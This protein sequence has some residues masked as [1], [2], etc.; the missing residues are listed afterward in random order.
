MPTSKYSQWKQGQFK[1][2][3]LSKYKGS[4]P[5]IYRS[6][7]EYKVMRFFDINEN[8]ISWGSESVVIRY[9]HPIKNKL[10]SYYTDFNVEIKDASNIVRKYLIE[11]KPY[12]QTLPP[13]AHGNKKQKTILLEN[14]MYLINSAKWSAAKEW[15]DKNNY[16]FNIL[17]EKDIKRYIK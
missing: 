1:P 11:V 13:S 8:V 2:H 9:M 6:S 4:H 10:A 12:K 3:N 17:T 7:L 5:I 16:I 14:A 15:C